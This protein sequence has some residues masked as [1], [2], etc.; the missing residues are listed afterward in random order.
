MNPSGS[1]K[2][3]PIDWPLPGHEPK[4][5]RILV[6]DD[7]QIVRVALLKILRMHGFT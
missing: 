2:A 5:I 1:P 4:D 7:Q 6:V 3:L